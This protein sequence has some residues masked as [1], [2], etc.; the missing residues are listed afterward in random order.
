LM[1]DLSNIS[2]N[3]FPPFMSITNNFIYLLGYE[4]STVCHNFFIGSI[5][6]LHLGLAWI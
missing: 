5:G 2:G 4:Y 1:N 6:E 3:E